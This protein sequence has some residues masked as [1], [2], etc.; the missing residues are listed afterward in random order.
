MVLFE[1]KKSVEWNVEEV[2]A[3]GVFCSASWMVALWWRNGLFTVIVLRYAKEC[4]EV[5][6][7]C[8]DQA[9]NAFYDKAFIKDT[10]G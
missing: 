1:D 5:D 3:L 2:Y 9:F 4:V 6:G 7:V 8:V 10:W